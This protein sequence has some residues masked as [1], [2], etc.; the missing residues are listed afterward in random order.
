[1]NEKYTSWI[2]FVHE[3]EDKASENEHVDN[4]NGIDD[5]MCSDNFNVVCVSEDEQSKEVP[6]ANTY[7]D[8]DEYLVGK[9]FDEG[10]EFRPALLCVI[11]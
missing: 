8:A 11:F 6:D 4:N 5:F 9:V 10:D 2:I 7:E 1:M 3:N